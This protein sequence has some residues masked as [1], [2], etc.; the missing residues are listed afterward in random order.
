MM[1]DG[2]LQGTMLVE[3]L[4]ARSAHTL[5]VDVYLFLL[6]SVFFT[7]KVFAGPLTNDIFQITFKGL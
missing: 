1:L 5:V 6:R 4:S 7:F 2:D 3:N